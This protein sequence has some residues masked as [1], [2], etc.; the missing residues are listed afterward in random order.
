L[1][2]HCIQYP[3]AVLTKQTGLRRKRSDLL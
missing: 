1:S 2:A 3:D